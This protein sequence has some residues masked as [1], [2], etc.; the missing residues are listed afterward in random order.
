[1]NGPN[2]WQRI[3]TELQAANRWTPDVMIAGGCIR[4]WMLGLEPK[5][6]DVFML[7]PEGEA[8]RLPE[9]NG[10]EVDPEQP[11]A[12]ENQGV[13]GYGGVT[14]ITSIFNWRKQGQPVQIIQLQRDTNLTDYVWGFDIDVCM[15]RW[16]QNGLNIPNSMA[17]DLEDKVIHTNVESENTYQR[18]DRFLRKVSQVEAGWRIAGAAA[19]FGP[20]QNPVLDWAVADEMPMHELR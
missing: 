8:P 4:D 2:F 9:G 16:D 3:R 10:W 17:R 7:L 14:R 1:M 6:I 18:A 19:R 13:P 12:P 5:D 15:G 20:R 11:Q